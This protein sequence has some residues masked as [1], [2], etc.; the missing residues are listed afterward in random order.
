MSALF[1]SHSSADNRVAD[2]LRAQLAARGHRSVFLDFDPERGIPAG[3]HWERELYTQ[4]RACQ[5]MIVLC[6]PASMASAWCFAEITHARAM[7]KP[8]F[9]LKFADCEVWPLLGDLQITDL[10]P[11]RVAGWQRLLDG[12]AAAGLDAGSLFDWDISRPPYPGLLAFQRDDAAVYFGRDAAIQSMIESLNRQRRLGGARLL[13]LLGA[14]GSG[15]SSLMRA[16]VLPRLARDG[17]GWC[18]APPFRPLARPLDALAVALAALPGAGPWKPLRDALAAEQSQAYAWNDLVNDVRAGAGAGAG[19]EAGLLLVVDQFEE[20]LGAVGEAG[21]DGA[22]PP[23]DFLRLLRAM[24][25]APDG[26]IFVVATLRSDFLGAFQTHPALQGMDY[27]PIHLPQIGLAELGQV[28]E[29]P[30]RVAGITLEPGLSQAMVADTATDDALPLLAFTLRELYDRF[31][32]GLRRGGQLTIDQYRVQLGGLQGALARAA[33]SLCGGVEPSSQLLVPLRRALLKLVRIDGEGRFVRQPCAW[34]DL[35]AEALPLLDKFVQARLLVARSED[36][37]TRVLEVAH[38][39]L[40]RSWD[41]LAVWLAEDR[42][43]LLWRAR[44][45][46]AVDEWRRNRQEASLLLRGPVLAEAQRWLGERGDDLDDPD[47]SFITAS[48][49]QRNAEQAAIDRRR[50]RT[51]LALLAAALVFGALAAAAGWQWRQADVQRQLATVQSQLALARQLNAQ[52]DLAQPRDPVLGLLLTVQSLHAAW[53]PDGHGALLERLDTLARPQASRWLPHPE[54][55]LA[56]AQS[57]DGRWLA[58]AG[59]GHLQLQSA[60]G[61]QRALYWRNGHDYLNALAFSPQG[62]R[63]AATCEPEAVC[64]YDLAA[65]GADPVLRLAVAKGPINALGFSV[66]G[67]LLAVTS[68]YSGDVWLFA[69]PA[70]EALPPI[71]TS[72]DGLRALSLSPDGQHLALATRNGLEIWQLA[73]RRRVGQLTAATGDAL[74]YSPEGKRLAV[75]GG[76]LPQVY[77]MGDGGDGDVTLT[78]L[79]QAGGSARAGPF[80]RIGFSR[81]GRWL[82]ASD[83]LTGLRF[84]EQTAEVRDGK[85]LPV[86]TLAPG[87]AAALAFGAGHGLLA[88]GRDGRMLAWDPDDKPLRRLPH[89]ADLHA[90]ALDANGRRLA[91]AAAGDQLRLIDL[92]SA[93]AAGRD[94]HRLQLACDPGGLAFSADGRWLAVIS[95]KLLR[96]VDTASGRVLGPLVHEDRVTGVWFEPGGQRLATRTAWHAM[97]GSRYG[98]WRP[99]RLRVWD[100]ATAGELGWRFDVA[101]D[102]QRASTVAAKASLNAVTTT[103]GGD[104]ALAAAAAAAW[105]LA[106]A[107]DDLNHYAV[108][109]VPAQARLKAT[110]LRGSALWQLALQRASAADGGGDAVGRF[111]FSGD[112]RLL[113]SIAGREARL[114]PLQRDDLVA[115]ACQRL[116]RNLSCAEWREALG[117]LPYARSCPQRPEPPDAA[118]CTATGATSR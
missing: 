110:L 94:L 35:P 73:K 2:E 65:A 11:D 114:W 33:E 63:L 92:G 106:Y 46:G 100:I 105:P 1:I 13:L 84:A 93:D 85:D 103:E 4:L 75:G 116:P 5:A 57:A 42:E 49:A 29:G 55:V 23:T 76:A 28:I 15:K 44:L 104:G 10:R 24:T 48:L 68:R 89:D 83:R 79:P 86:I 18:V 62:D 54:T 107:G 40:F 51:S 78:A 91:T 8:L 60:Q 12:L 70:G 87:A 50:R 115:E 25:A 58:T 43:F 64:L 88:G 67:R 36:G 90:V 30:A 21:A 20:A 80:S 7:G 96:L 113:A 95:G 22:A 97:G 71:S 26:P 118:N 109:Q 6:S 117:E 108:L 82:A 81:D 53:T 38:E 69:L 112:G 19:N 34:A 31:G 66:D 3:R 14:S 72:A 61:E 41:R 45:R 59:Q 39:A 56:M 16:G 9:P 98:I 101:G 32:D 111:G 74:A 17:E 99:T 27:A 37:G 77:A 47:R 52:A 102:L